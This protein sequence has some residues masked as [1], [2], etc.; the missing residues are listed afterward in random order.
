MKHRSTSR[1]VFDKEE[2]F[3]IKELLDRAATTFE[4]GAVVDGWILSYRKTHD[5]KVLDSIL[6]QVMKFIV[7]TAKKYKTPSI[8]V[9]DLIIEAVISVIEVIN[10][11]YKISGKQKFITYIKIVIDR[12]IKDYCDTINQAVHLPKNIKSQQGKLKAKGDTKNLIYAKVNYKSI[13]QLATFSGVQRTEDATV[14]DKLSTESLTIDLMR[15][16]NLKLDATERYI[17][18]YTYGI[19]YDIEK[20][21][22]VIATD[23]KISMKEVEEIKRNA[24]QKLQE[25]A[26]AKNLLVKYLDKLNG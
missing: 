17:I 23:L 10:T 6:N 25:S 16:L 18:M 13:R 11:H 7:Y 15:V 20:S 19:K 1:L 26:S 14:E 21:R 12:K 3:A 4:N 8:D 2:V 24:L 22:R 9:R 5:P